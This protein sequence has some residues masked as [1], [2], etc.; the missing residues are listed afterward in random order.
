MVGVAPVLFTFRRIENWFPGLQLLCC[1]SGEIFVIDH[2]RNSL[3]SVCILPTGIL[4]LKDADCHG[5]KAPS[6]WQDVRKCFRWLCLSEP[7][8]ARRGNPSLKVFISCKTIKT[9]KHFKNG[10]P[11]AQSALAMTEGERIAP[12]GYFPALC[13]RAPRLLRRLAMTAWGAEIELCYP[14]ICTN[15]A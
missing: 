12:R 8:G 7:C 14:A 9:P 15:L 6:Q 5:R 13:A 4:F 10:L 11:R 3:L 1:F 2:L